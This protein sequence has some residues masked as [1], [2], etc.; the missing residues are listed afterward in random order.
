[1]MADDE[2]KHYNTFKSLSAKS[3]PEM[4]KTTVLKDA[5]N[6]FQDIAVNLGQ[7]GGKIDVGAPQVEHYRSA[8]KVEKESYELYES[9]AKLLGSGP[10]HDLL[11]QIAKEE[12]A[13]ELLMHNLIEFVSRP[14][15][16]IS[17]AEFRFVFFLLSL[18]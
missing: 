16:W 2:L 10:Q 5:K 17:D 13:H 9:K 1:M 18:F 14:E 12:R 6:V 4:R 3:T 8:E 7:T 11:M 15:T